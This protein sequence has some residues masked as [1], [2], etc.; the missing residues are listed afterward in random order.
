MPR[1]SNKKINL[2]PHP[3]LIGRS[4]PTKNSVISLLT[5]LLTGD[6]LRFLLFWGDILCLDMLGV[7]LGLMPGAGP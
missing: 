3:P 2:D 1:L 6:I 4:D 7:P 5:C